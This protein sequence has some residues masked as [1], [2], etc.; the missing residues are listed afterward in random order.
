MKKKFDLV[1]GIIGVFNVL[2]KLA[3]CPS[4]ADRILWFEISGPVYLIIWSTISIIVLY[5][6]YQA[7]WG[8]KEIDKQA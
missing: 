4:C 5:G 3:T 2:Y 1:I 8:T 7:N 6:F